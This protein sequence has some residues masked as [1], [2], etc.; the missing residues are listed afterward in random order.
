LRTL[1][2]FAKEPIPGQVKTRL[3]ASL[4]AVGA[5]RVYRAF[6][7][8]VAQHLTKLREVRLEW[9]VDGN[10]RNIASEIQH[11]RSDPTAPP[12]RFHR[13]PEGELGHR[14]SRAFDE[15]FTA[16]GQP[17]V[18]IGTD[19]PL[20]GPTHLEDLFSAVEADADA[21]LIPTRDGGYAALALAE[22]APEAFTGI[23]WSTETVLELTLQALRTAGR[24]VLLL[25]TLYDVD[26]GADLTQ[27]TEDLRTD[28]SA[29]PETAHVLHELLGAERWN[30]SS[31]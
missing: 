24:T 17:V 12:V 8:D 20:L 7:V 27:L 16:G 26:T 3:A 6:L 9:W 4:G 1:I 13:Q 23:P 21:A 11:A 28:P 22:P 19:C 29:A 5:C 14:L 31:E 18:V 2:V 25:P 30:G 15:A 10:P